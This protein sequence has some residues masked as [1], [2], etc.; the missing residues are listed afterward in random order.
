MST[1]EWLEGRLL[2][3]ELILKFALTNHVH[4][5]FPPTLLAGPY[6]PGGVGA[7]HRDIKRR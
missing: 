1:W 2:A 5:L 6:A 4:Y 3:Y 7:P